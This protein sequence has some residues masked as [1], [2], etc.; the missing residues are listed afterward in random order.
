MIKFE[1]T[2]VVG[3]EVAILGIRNPMNSLVS[4]SSIGLRRCHIRS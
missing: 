2:E 3:C 4:V 1:N